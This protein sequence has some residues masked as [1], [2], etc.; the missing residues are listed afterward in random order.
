MDPVFWAQPRSDEARGAQTHADGPTA[1]FVGESGR[2]G[3]LRVCL[4]VEACAEKPVVSRGASWVKMRRVS[5]GALF[6]DLPRP[7]SGPARKRRDSP[8]VTF[9]DREEGGCR[10]ASEGLPLRGG[11]VY[12]GHHVVQ[13][14]GHS[15]ATRTRRLPGTDDKPPGRINK[16]RDIEAAVSVPFLPRPAGAS[17]LSVDRG[18]GCR[19]LWIL[20]VSPYLRVR[21]EAVGQEVICLPYG[22]GDDRRR[23]NEQDAGGRLRADFGELLAEGALPATATVVAPAVLTFAA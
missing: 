2:R 14:K 7:F 20:G 21:R 3:D 8:V 22:H 13:Q 11:M 4:L 10:A 12:N 9:V 1:A 17:C 19:A 23:A 15:A 16:A 5:G 18:A 6:W